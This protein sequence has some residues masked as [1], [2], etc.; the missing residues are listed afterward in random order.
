MRDIITQQSGVT[1]PWG[2]KQFTVRYCSIGFAENTWMLIGK[3]IA[4]F[5]ISIAVAILS[6]FWA[7]P[8]FFVKLGK[9]F[10]NTAK[11][12]GGNFVRGDWHTR[13]SYAV[14]GL[15]NLTRGQI[16]RGLFFF[17]IE[18]ANVLY[19]IFIGAG[20]L[21]KF[22][23][24]GTEVDHFVEDPNSWDGVILVPGD[25][26][27]DILLV[28]VVTLVILVAFVALYFL[29]IKSAIQAQETARAGKPLPK[30]KQEIADFKDKK[31]HI[32]LLTVPILG[33]MIVNI[34]PIIFMIFMAFTNFDKLHIP[35]GSLFTWVGLDVFKQLL[36]A[37][38]PRL[39][40][41]FQSL[42]GW[43][44]TWAVLA[45]VLNF[46]LGMLLA[47]V[48]NR[49]GIMGKK[50][51]RT[52]FVLTIAVPQFVSLLVMR[53]IFADTGPINGLIVGAGGNIVPFWGNATLA[54]VMVI[55]VNLWV[56]IPYSM[57]IT[58]GILMN[59]PKDIYEAARIDGASG[60]QAFFKITLPYVLFVTGPYLV[61][62]FIGNINNFNVIYLLTGG[63][64]T[65]SAFYNA[66]GTDLLVTWLYKLSMDT[67]DYNL[68]S[69]IGIIVFL[70]SAFFSLVIFRK[71]NRNEEG[72]QL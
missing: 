32:T 50:L 7:I 47:I 38:N 3:K 8:R 71:I 72:M 49:K 23:T 30:I 2:K 12:Y 19:M 11:W 44:I 36:G 33:V 65:N 13:L 6:F 63:G 45:T 16:A 62:Q 43:T 42:L 68:A 27:R 51:W 46:F 40:L 5:F 1:F 20:A 57:L 39:A 10:V 24:L 59:V 53:S 41:T 28:G 25:N 66:G 52:I 60:P 55:L 15:G 22:G 64:P 67:Q 18:V 9:G 31:F 61:T 17:F 69:A 48:I 14:M 54:R 26:S 37:S 56:G 29:S 35:P 58:S 4:N 34:I 21:A 70:L